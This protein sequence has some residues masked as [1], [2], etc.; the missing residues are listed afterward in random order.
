MRW[1]ADITEFHTGESKLYIAGDRDLS[2]R[3]LVGWSMH[4]HQDV[5]LV[6]APWSWPRDAATPTLT[7]SSVTRQP[8]S[9]RRG[10]S[11]RR[12]G[13]IRRAQPAQGG[14]R[15]GEHTHSGEAI[16]TRCPS[17]ASDTTH[18]TAVERIIEVPVADTER[19]HRTTPIRSPERAHVGMS[20]A[21]KARTS[22][23]LE[24]ERC[25]RPAWVP[26]AIVSGVALDPCR[27]SIDASCLIAWSMTSAE[28]GPQAHFRFRDPRATPRL[29][30]H[31][32]ACAHH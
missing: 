22:R 1:V 2:H 29:L 14:A 16:A 27:Y 24:P 21:S 30:C 4:E 5:E 7:G 18:S 32:R 15:T 6:V 3:Y 11:T 8:E 26:V 10:P 13:Q 23:R 19:K 28:P 17:C 20:F 9:R 12:W 25:V 31:R